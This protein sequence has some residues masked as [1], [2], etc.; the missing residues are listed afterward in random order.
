[1]KLTYWI[2]ECT[3]DAQCYNIRQRTKKAAIAM[4]ATYSDSFTQPPHKVVVEYADAFDLM[5]QCLT[6]GGGNWESG[7]YRLP[8]T[9]PERS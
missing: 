7:P 5:E 3:H 1:M 8:E 4:A 9:H 6:E 2:V